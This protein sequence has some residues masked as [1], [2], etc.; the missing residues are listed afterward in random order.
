MIYRV[1]VSDEA[2]H[3]LSEHM[4]FIAEKNEDAARRLTGEI[5]KAITSLDHMP[6]RY[7]F[8]NEPY[9]PQNKYRKMFVTG[10]Y[11]VLYQIREDVV[12]VD[13]VMDCRQDFQHLMTP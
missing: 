9:I 7:P 1:I 3:M 4:R 11:L 6:Q 2:H 12:L 13:W 8:F 10:H 5:I